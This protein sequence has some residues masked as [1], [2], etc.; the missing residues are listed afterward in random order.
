MPAG[1]AGG[2]RRPTIVYSGCTERAW[3]L[4]AAGPALAHPALVSSSPGAGRAGTVPPGEVALAFSQP[5]TLP[6]RPLVVT[7]QLL[8]GAA[9]EP[10]D[11]RLLGRTTIN[12]VETVTSGFGTVLSNRSRRT[13][14]EFLVGQP[15]ADGRAV[16]ATVA[17]RDGG[18]TLLF[19]V[20]LGYHF[21]YP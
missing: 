18:R 6:D 7:T 14:Q 15:C 3:L 13:G 2:R 20:A 21:A 16:D 1:R 17:E 8:V 10:G 12:T 11:G 5:V 19:A 4:G 9:R